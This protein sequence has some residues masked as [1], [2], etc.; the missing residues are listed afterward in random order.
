M[1]KIWTIKIVNSEVGELAQLLDS[2]GTVI[3]VA[4]T[5]ELINNYQEE[6]YKL[7]GDCTVQKI[8]CVAS[9][10]HTLIED[11][12]YVLKIKFY[13]RREKKVQTKKI[14]IWTFYRNESYLKS[15][16]EEYFKSLNL[17]YVSNLDSLVDMMWDSVKKKVKKKDIPFD[18]YV[19]GEI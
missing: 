18:R 3:K 6:I 17:I 16:F 15:Y 5:D 1:N 12:G 9:C 13:N 10:H 4:P 19:Y 14:V 2:N 8:E 11:S 7:S